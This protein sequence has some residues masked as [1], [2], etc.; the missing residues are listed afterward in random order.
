M[1][2]YIKRL[3]VLLLIA[4]FSKVLF[5]H[6]PT[7]V[8]GGILLVV[9]VCSGFYEAWSQLTEMK[10][11]QKEHDALKERQESLEKQ[12]ESLKSYV[13]SIKLGSQIMRTTNVQR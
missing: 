4:Y 5:L 1:D 10:R 13:S 6:Q 11:L 12:I 3:P 8:D 9:A 2:K 7:W